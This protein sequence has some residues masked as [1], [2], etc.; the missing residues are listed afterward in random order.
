MKHSMHLFSFLYMKLNGAWMV[1]AKDL[2]IKE[3][4]I[5]DLYIH[6]ATLFK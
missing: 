2:I 4:F 6:G 1:L 3:T 5:F